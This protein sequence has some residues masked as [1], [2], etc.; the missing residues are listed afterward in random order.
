FS[1]TLVWSGAHVQLRPED[2][3]LSS[4][5][6]AVRPNFVQTRYNDGDTILCDWIERDGDTLVRTIN[7]ITDWA[8]LDRITLRYTRP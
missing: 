2:R 5:G 7:A 4:A 1:G 6:P 3:R 8:Y